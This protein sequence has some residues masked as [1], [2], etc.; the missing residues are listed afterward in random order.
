MNLKQTI[1]EVQA[2]V[3]H[4]EPSAT[5]LAERCFTQIEAQIPPATRF[6]R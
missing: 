4:A 5:G 2:A 3:R 1:P 6:W